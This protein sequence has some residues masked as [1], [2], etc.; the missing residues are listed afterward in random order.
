MCITH[1]ILCILYQRKMNSILNFI[2]NLM[3][4]PRDGTSF[5]SVSLHSYSKDHAPPL[6]SP[7]AFPQLFPL[8]LR[9]VKNPDVSI[10]PLTRPFVCFLTL[11]SHL[12]HCLHCSSALLHSLICSL[13]HSLACGKECF[14]N[15]MNASI[16]YSF[17]PLCGAPNNFDGVAQNDADWRRMAQNWSGLGFGGWLWF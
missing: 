8:W 1:S 10:G 3:Q 4:N 7:Q 13:T 2:T 6:H 11:L 14:F 9:T 15:I 12:L 16:S 5:H 17:N